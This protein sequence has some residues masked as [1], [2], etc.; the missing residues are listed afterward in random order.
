MSTQI[1]ETRNSALYDA[2]KEIQT[3]YANGLI[4]IH[5]MANNM[6][7]VS[8]EIKALDD[9][10]ATYVKIEKKYAPVNDTIK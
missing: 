1:F 4:T 7:K 6:K 5:E 10:W 3:E 2:I 8:T 9:D